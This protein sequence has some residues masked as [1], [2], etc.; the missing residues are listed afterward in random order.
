M[1]D[2]VF[3]AKYNTFGTLGDPS[4]VFPEFTDPRFLSPGAPIGG[5]AGIRIKL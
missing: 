4:N 1:I 3:D 2:N 5:W